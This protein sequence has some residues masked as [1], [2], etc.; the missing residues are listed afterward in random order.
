MGKN[1][2]A[3]TL[4]A[5]KAHN[6]LNK[7]LDNTFFESESNW[8][9]LTVNWKWNIQNVEFEKKDILNNE[10]KITKAIKEAWNKVNL[11]VTKIQKEK[12]DELTEKLKK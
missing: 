1:E 3:K 4:A 6:K 9:V 12:Y 2:N 5:L 10:L 11:H 7:E 8:L